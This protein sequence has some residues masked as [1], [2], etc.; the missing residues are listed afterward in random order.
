MIPI[1]RGGKSNRVEGESKKGAISRREKRLRERYL[2]RGLAERP[3]GCG[4]LYSREV[5]HLNGCEY[6][7]L[8]SALG[9]KERGRETESTQEKSATTR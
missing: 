3:S 2:K 7:P 4:N 6:L 9:D 1:V 5:P 8:M